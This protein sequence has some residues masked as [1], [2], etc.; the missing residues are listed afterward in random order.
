MKKLLTIATLVAL[1]MPVAAK[2]LSTPALA[3]VWSSVNAN[4]GAL[5]GTIELRADHTLALSPQGKPTFQGTWATEP[6]EV[7]AL[8]IPE[9]GQSSMQY[10][11]RG[12]KLT[13]TYDNGNSQEFVRK[14]NRTSKKGS[15]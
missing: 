12:N 5:A 13:L 8:T 4:K 14:T 10:K 7:L 2:N 6:A 1:A 11:V 9:A 3:G 15:K